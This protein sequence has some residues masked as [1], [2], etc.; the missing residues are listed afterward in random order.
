MICSKCHKHFP[1]KDG[2]ETDE[3]LICPL[4]VVEYFPL[5]KGWDEMTEQEKDDVARQLS[6]SFYLAARFYS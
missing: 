3:G 1:E 4:C 5:P 6:N 2:L